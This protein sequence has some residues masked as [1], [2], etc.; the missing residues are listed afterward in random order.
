[1]TQ[2]NRPM[3]F[4]NFVENAQAIFDG[5][6]NEQVWIQGGLDRIANCKS[7]KQ[8]TVLL[9]DTMKKPPAAFRIL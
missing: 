4:D 8:A 6:P 3:T 9:F 2:E 5:F 1:M 7:L